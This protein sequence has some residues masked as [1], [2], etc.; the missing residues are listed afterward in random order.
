MTDSTSPDG[1]G[2]TI[3]LHDLL[4]LDFTFDPGGASGAVVTLPVGPGAIG[5]GGVLHGGAIATAVDLASALAA[6]QHH[7]IDFV[8]E[9]LITTDLHVR[10]LG[11]PK[12]D[13]VEVHAEV[14]RD[15]R[16]LIV[17]AC[18]VRDSGGHLVASADVGMMAV[19]RRRP[20]P[21]TVD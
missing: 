18:S 17:V 3:P 7:P 13:T 5:A 20:L 9:S 10:Y 12:T 4:G 15:G 8:T 11:Q 19:T 16:Q 14:I 6:V 21:D 2:P 1:P